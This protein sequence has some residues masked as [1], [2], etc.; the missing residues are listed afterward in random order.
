MIEERIVNGVCYVMSCDIAESEDD[1]S[2]FV[3]WERLADGSLRWCGT[4]VVSS[5]TGAIVKESKPIDFK[6]G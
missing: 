3:V 5:R 6:A 4:R 1:Y 2:A